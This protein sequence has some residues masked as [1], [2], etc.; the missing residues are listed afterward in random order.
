M[1]LVAAYLKRSRRPLLASERKTREH[2]ARPR[3][4]APVPHELYQVNHVTTTTVHGVSVH[5]LVPATDAPRDTPLD[6]VIYLHGGTYLNGLDTRHWSLVSDLAGA[7]VRVLVPDYGLA[8]DHGVDA[9]LALLDEVYTAAQATAERTGHRV[10]LAGDSAG[11]GLALGWLLTRSRRPA[12]VRVALVSPWL[13][14]TCTTPGLD[15]LVDT[16][17]FLHP[18]GL[19]V[20]GQAWADAGGVD[21]RY[22][23]VSPLAATDGQFRSL[24]EDPAVRIAVWTG[25]RDILSADARALDERLRDADIPAELHV[26][27]GA[28]HVHPLTPTPEGRA[29]RAAVIDWLTRRD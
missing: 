7:G 24:A 6:T 13:D 19:R 4:S 21:V 26:C 20:A 27:P 14:V 25:T 16:D 2:M 8:P 10:R 5:S 1:R 15:D 12:V 9:A 28:V 29:A 23:S 22:P 11:G 17:P 18:A 3:T